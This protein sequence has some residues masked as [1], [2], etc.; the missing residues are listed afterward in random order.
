MAD[1]PQEKLINAYNAMLAHLKEYWHEAEEKTLPPLK[2]GLEKAAEKASELG[3]LTREESEKVGG[4]VK[5][6]L[7]QAANYLSDNGKQLKDWL[8]FDLEFAESKF[9]EM[10][11]NLA[12]KTRVELDALA[13]QARQVGEWHT[14]EVTGIGTLE[15][16]QCGEKLHFEKTGHIPPC[17][18]CRA[19]VFKKSYGE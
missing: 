3:E 14:G 4:Y 15:C 16:K 5:K 8:K 1:S 13:E 11:A 10:F 7:E 2:E 19:T 17:P 18:K 6:D 12:D 9:A